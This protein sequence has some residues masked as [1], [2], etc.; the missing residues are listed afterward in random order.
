[1]RKGDLFPLADHYHGD[2]RSD[3]WPLNGERANIRAQFTGEFRPPKKGEWYLSGAVVEA[4]RAPN[5]LST[6]YYIARIVWVEKT[7]I[8][9]VREI[10]PN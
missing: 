9:S 5:D 6:P 3:F 8:Y 10:L 2:L 4:Y 1:M 7:V